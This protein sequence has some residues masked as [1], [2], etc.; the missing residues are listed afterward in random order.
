MHF[1]E[2]YEGAAVFQARHHTFRG[3][4]RANSLVF[5]GVE[6]F[7]RPRRLPQEQ[8]RTCRETHGAEQDFVRA[9]V[10]EQNA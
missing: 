10:L 6:V 8:P 7:A 5:R 9:A 2:I 1:C 4:G 3:N